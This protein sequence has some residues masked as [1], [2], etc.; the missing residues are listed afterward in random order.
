MHMQLMTDTTLALSSST[1][2]HIAFGILT[3]ERFL[4]TRLASQ[5]HTWLRDVRHV[6]YYSESVIAV[7]DFAFHSCTLL[8]PCS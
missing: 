3:S 1:V 8:G 7:R 4:D 6:V 2:D 5:R